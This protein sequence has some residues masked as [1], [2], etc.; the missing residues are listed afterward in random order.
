MK[1]VELNDLILAIYD[2]MINSNGWAAVLERVSRYIG[3][4]GAFIFELEG[5]GNQRYIRAPYY[6]EN[7][8]PELVSSY[9]ASHNDQ[10]LL[11]Q[12]TFARLSRPTDQIQLISEEVLAES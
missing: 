7:Y 8:N 4:R 6:S 11:D 12:D 10:E 1:T 2:T 3:A 9:L 5:V